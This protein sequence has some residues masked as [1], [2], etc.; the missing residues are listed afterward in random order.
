M[1]T[2]GRAYPETSAYP[3][4]IPDQGTAPLDYKLLAGQ[5][6]VL[7]DANVETDYYRAVTYDTPP[8]ADHIDIRGTTK[9]LQISFGHR[10]MYVKASDV[11][12]RPAR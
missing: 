10:I 5:A 2:Y 8:P 11:V 6:A 12:V 4:G 3:A 9:Y 7:S 1:T